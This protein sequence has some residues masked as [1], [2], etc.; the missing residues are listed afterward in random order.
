MYAGC[1]PDF[2]VYIFPLLVVSYIKLSN[3]ANV[4]YFHCF[5]ES[6]VFCMFNPY[7]TF[8]RYHMLCKLSQFIYTIVFGLLSSKTK[9]FLS[10]KTVLIFMY[11]YN[12]IH[13][14][15]PQWVLN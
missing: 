10:K 13:I 15:Q 14:R 2:L 8:C 7:I 6:K 9:T 4:Q 11:M 12:Q 1:M 5:V 3:K